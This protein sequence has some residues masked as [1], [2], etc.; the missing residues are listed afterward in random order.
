LLLQFLQAIE[1][2]EMTP[3]EVLLECMLRIA[4]KDSEVKAWVAVKPQEGAVR[5]RL[6]GIPFGAKDI[7]ETAGLPTEYGSPLYEGRKG[8]YDAHVIVDLKR[9]GAV[10]IGKTRT[11]PFASFDPTPTRNPRLPGHTPGGSSSGSAA[12]VAAEMV[13]FAIGTQTLGSVLRPA[14]F[15]G[16][17]GF[18]PTFGL[19]STEGVMPFAPSLDT[20]GLFAATAAD[21]AALWQRG[22][23]GRPAGSLHRAARFHLPCEEP[24]ENALDDAVAR[25]RAAGAEI[26]EFDPPDGWNGLVDAARIINTFEGARTQGARFAEF[27]QRIGGRLADL[28]CAGQ[29]LP[30]DE[31]QSARAHVEA[32]K[33]EMQSFFR[34]YPGVLTPAALGPAPAGLES[35]GDP[36]HNAPWT[37][38]GT[39]S[40]SVPLP[41]AGAPLGMQIAAAWGRDDAL[42]AMAASVERELASTPYTG[43]E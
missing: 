23:G 27:G 42:V 40:I 21:L 13:P 34:E 41:V 30:W 43:K 14:S 33:V 12:A 7:I 18:K 11:T 10:L 16:I 22:F 3:T 24:M 15:C 32:M 6:Y 39:P 1:S 19:L 17:C 31:Y 9:S 5:G 29:R 35:T 4:A 26:D 8:E 2:G 28:V 25:L 37:A 36:V 20:V 38:L